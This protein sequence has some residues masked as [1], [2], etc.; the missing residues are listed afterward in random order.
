MTIYPD[1]NSVCQQAR[2]HLEQREFVKAWYLLSQHKPRF[3]SNAEF[4]GLLNIA[5]LK[6]LPSWHFAMLN[7][8]ARNHFFEQAITAAVQPGDIVLDIGTGSGLLAMMAVRAGAAHVYACEANPVMAGLAQEMIEQNGFAEKI[9]ILPKHSGELRLGEDL[10]ERADVLIT[11]TFSELIVGEGVLRVV[12]QAR[13]HFLK[14]Q[15][16]VVPEEAGLIGTPYESPDI[17]DQLQVNGG[18]D[19]CGFDLSAL[20]KASARGSTLSSVGS[21][22]ERRVN[23]DG[24]ALGQADISLLNFNLRNDALMDGQLLSGETQHQ[25]NMTHA[26][27]FKEL[28][29]HMRLKSHGLTYDTAEM[30]S[31][32]HWRQMILSLSRN[33]S[34]GPGD[35]VNLTFW[36]SFSCGMGFYA[37]VVPA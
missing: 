21:L 16:I 5:L 35:K 14:P 2:T 19:V 13:Q 36:H 6:V 9:T 29:L 28:K 23:G 18:A 37:D 34:V 27:C 7:D 17:E 22:N 3:R 1:V 11:E 8:E 31:G 20:D 33:L 32:A 24:R 26:G 15:A 25:I 30:G 12:H 10:P 4:R